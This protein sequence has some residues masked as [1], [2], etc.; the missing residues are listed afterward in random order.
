MSRPSLNSIM[1]IQVGMRLIVSDNLQ[2]RV[3]GDRSHGHL[4]IGTVI[5]KSRPTDI[6]QDDGTVMDR[7]VTVELGNFYYPIEGGTCDVDLSSTEY[8]IHWD[9]VADDY[10]PPSTYVPL[11]DLTVDVIDLTGDDDDQA[12]DDMAIAPA[13]PH[14]QCCLAD[15]GM[16]CTEQGWSFFT[17]AHTL[18]MPCAERLQGSLAGQDPHY[19]R[20]A[21]QCPICRSPRRE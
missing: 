10:A 2:W 13:L 1:A 18:C 15:T 12:G 8:G 11:I 7:Y 17:C 20:R 6:L 14:G 21:F 16:D 5:A 9:I 19:P 3:D 4:N